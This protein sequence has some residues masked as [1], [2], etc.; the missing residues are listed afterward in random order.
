M[1]S[2]TDTAPDFRG[3]IRRQF[4]KTG[5]TILKTAELDLRDGGSLRSAAGTAGISGR[6]FSQ[7]VSDLS[8]GFDIPG[9]ERLAMDFRDRIGEP[10]TF[11]GYMDLPDARPC[12]DCVLLT[13]RDGYRPMGL[14]PLPEH[15]LGMHGVCDALDG[16]DGT[17]VTDRIP[18]SDEDVRALDRWGS[19]WLLTEPPFPETSSVTNQRMSVLKHRGRDYE[20][21]K[22]RYDKHWL[23][24]FTDI[25]ERD[26]IL[27]DIPGMHA[28]RKDAAFLRRAAGITDS[29]SSQ[30]FDIR[31]VRRMADIRSDWNRTMRSHWIQLESDAPQTRDEALGLLCLHVISDMARRYDAP[32]QSIPD[33]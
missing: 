21:C 29:L 10:P 14:V 22:V 15:T 12:L 30:S 17:L 31:E 13:S 23:F 11:S 27:A 3:E 9:R 7:A 8:K 26:R 24:R 6:E 2:V 25:A 1:T 18:Y 5:D 4:P 33:F 28:N 19:D 16:F 32:V 20:T